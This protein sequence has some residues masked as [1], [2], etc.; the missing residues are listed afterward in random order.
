MQIYSMVKR[1]VSPGASSQLSTMSQRNLP[2][3]EAFPHATGTALETVN[4]H[5][6]EQ[7]LVLWGS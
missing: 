3:T 5:A 7:E 1:M 4:S 2:D 6:E